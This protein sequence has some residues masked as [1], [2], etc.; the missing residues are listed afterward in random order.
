MTYLKELL[1]LTY[2]KYYL[3]VTS[4]HSSQNNHFRSPALFL[5]NYGSNQLCNTCRLSRIIRET[6]YL[7]PQQHYKSRLQH[8]IYRIKNLHDLLNGVT[9]FDLPKIEFALDR[10]I[11]HPAYSTSR[12]ADISGCGW[13]G[14]PESTATRPTIPQPLQ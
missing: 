4:P 2:Q 13:S 5:Q 11:S 9:V 1:Y 7:S 14:S 12:S 3:N 8:Y 6:M 10:S